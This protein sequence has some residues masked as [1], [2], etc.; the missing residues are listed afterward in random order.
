MSSCSRSS[1]ARFA[2]PG[3]SV[4]DEF[5]RL[6]DVMS[7]CGF[8][9]LVALTVRFAPR[10][11]PPLL[12]FLV[13]HCRRRDL[14][15]HSGA[16]S[17]SSHRPGDLSKALVSLDSAHPHTFSV[18]PETAMSLTLCA[19]TRDHRPSSAARAQ[20]PAVF[21]SFT[22]HGAPQAS[23]RHNLVARTSHADRERRLRRRI[24]LVVVSACSRAVRSASRPRT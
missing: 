24:T 17:V 12:R 3:C 19:P 14:R 16:P 18:R 13:R 22:S 7:R 20:S 11:H 21:L 4:E 6:G 10:A 2:G 1:R 5:F 15:A 9:F 23:D 8:S